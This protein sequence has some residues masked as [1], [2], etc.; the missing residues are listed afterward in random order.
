MANE[1]D[2]SEK[3]NRSSSLTPEEMAKA[4]AAANRAAVAEAAASHPTS[5]SDSPA[6]VKE[7]VAAAVAS[8]FASLAPMLEKLALTPDK[9][10]ALKAP[11]VDPLTS[12]REQRMNI[13]GREEEKRNREAEQWAKDNCAHKD[14]NDKDSICLNHNYP[15]RRPRGVCVLC[16]DVIHPKEWR[17]D[18]PDPLTGQHTKGGKNGEVIDGVY[19]RQGAYLVLAHKDYPRVLKLENQQS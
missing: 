12:A 15:D 17:L 2:N 6:L 18:A 5:A 8:V 11:Y 4:T 19:W 7:A 9:I 16:R 1:H 13:M 14:K 10:A 3:F